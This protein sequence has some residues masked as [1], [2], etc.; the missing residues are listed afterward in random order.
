ML[1][2]TARFACLALFMFAASAPPLTVNAAQLDSPLPM[3]DPGP[4]I[5][6]IMSALQQDS[7]LPMPDPG[8]PLP[9]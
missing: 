9:R 8:P 5:T 3:P 4:P 1:Q 7:P 2:Q 6:Q